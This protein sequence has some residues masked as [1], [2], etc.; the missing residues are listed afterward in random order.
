MNKIKNKPYIPPHA[1]F[2]DIIKSRLPVSKSVNE[3]LKQVLYVVML[4]DSTDLHGDITSEEEVRK[5]CHNYNSSDMKANLFHMTQTNTFSVIESYIAP[6]DFVLNDVIVKAG[7]WLA[8]LQIN[9]DV[10]WDLVKSGDICAVS[11]GAVANVEVL[12]E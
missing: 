12:D 7:T 6:V 8:K 2:T 1:D 3:E 9:D 11:I 5:A 10:V 4:P